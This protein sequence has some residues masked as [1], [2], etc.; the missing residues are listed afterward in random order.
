[1]I[2]IFLFNFAFATD[3]LDNCP[4][5]TE[6]VHENCVSTECVHKFHKDCLLE[7]FANS[8]RWNCPLCRTIVLV[9]TNYFDETVLRRWNIGQNPPN[10]QNSARNRHV[11][12]LSNEPNAAR[13]SDIELNFAPQNEQRRNSRGFCC[14]HP[15]CSCVFSVDVLYIM[16]I[17][18]GTIHTTK[19]AYPIVSMIFCVFSHMFLPTMF[20]GNVSAEY[21]VSFKSS[22]TFF[23]YATLFFLLQ[24][25]TQDKAIVGIGYAW[26]SIHLLFSMWA[27][28]AET[29]LQL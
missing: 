22:F 3:K 24:S 26:F 23:V 17:V 1:M 4:I 7:F 21:N 10:H 14:C 2:L 28:C 8:E 15:C 29:M 27:Y 20:I 19:Y 25:F 11:A 6:C 18:F 13:Y 5:C 16:A 12:L 9:P